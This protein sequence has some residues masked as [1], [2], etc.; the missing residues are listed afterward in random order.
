MTL[1]FYILNGK[2]DRGEREL[3][4]HEVSDSVLVLNREVLFLKLTLFLWKDGYQPG[5]RYTY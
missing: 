3:E 1:Y 5:F 4:D 2:A